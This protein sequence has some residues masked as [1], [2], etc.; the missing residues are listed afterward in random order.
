MN[1]AKKPEALQEFVKPAD[2][3]TLERKEM[4]KVLVP[5][6]PRDSSREEEVEPLPQDS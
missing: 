4:L 6:V 1:L 2:V 3:E 5:P